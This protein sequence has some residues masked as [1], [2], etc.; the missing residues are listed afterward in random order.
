MRVLMV[1]DVYFPRINGVSTSMQTFRRAIAAN[2]V[3]VQL[4]VP[5]YGDEPD[6]EG[7]TRVPGRPV[8]R[9]PEDRLMAWRTLRTATLREAA[10]CDVIHIQTPFAAHYAGLAAARKLAKPVLAT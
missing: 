3:E 10:S 6:E 5:R 1:S 9:D 2:G 4:L 7:I 8:P